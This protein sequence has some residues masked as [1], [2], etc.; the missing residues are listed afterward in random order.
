MQPSIH[1]GAS[2]D[3]DPAIRRLEPGDAPALAALRL[4]ALERE[5]LS[6]GSSVEDDRFRSPEFVVAVLGAGS[7]QAV[8]GSF[9]GEDLN[10]MVG[11]MRSSKNKE[12]HRADVWGMYVAPRARNRGIGA[13]LL[14]AVVQQAREWDLDQVHLGVTDA[15]PAAQRL[16]LRAGFRTWGV[17][18]RALCWGGRFVDEH[19][20]VL[21]LRRGSA[22]AP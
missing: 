3:A 10:G 4:E 6:F 19:H 13:A 7:E 8:F 9:E 21:E 14:A 2:Y 15:A 18:P 17:D 16:Y 22:R 20:L 1:T 5:P 11:I 12:R